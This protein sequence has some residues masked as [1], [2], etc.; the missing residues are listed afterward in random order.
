MPLQPALRN[1]VVNVGRSRRVS[2]RSVLVV[3]QVAL[4]LILLVLGALFVRGLQRAHD[5]DT[6]FDTR[7]VLTATL[8]PSMLGYDRDRSVRFYEALLER[9]RELPGVSSAAVARVVPL[10]FGTG[11]RRMRPEGYAQRPG[12]DMEEPFNIVSPGYFETIGLSLVRGRG[13][14][15]ADRAGAEMVVVV[16]EAFATRYWPGQDPLQIRLRADSRPDSPPL[17][18]VGVAANA[19]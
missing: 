5:I 13:F 17:R 8:D 10:T 15:E 18:V 2:L 6:G 3:M 16:N 14:T 9:V 1:D 11:R 12:E 7:N 4:S 19:K